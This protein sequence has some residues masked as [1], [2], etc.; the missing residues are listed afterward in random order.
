[1]R[2]TRTLLVGV[3]VAGL[4]LPGAPALG[5]APAPAAQAQLA[6]ATRVFG[7][8]AG[9]VL[10]FIK[11]DKTA[12]F[13]TVMA[14]VRDAL[15]GSDK[16]LRQQQARSWKVFKSPDPASGGAALYVFLSDPAVKGADYTITTILAET[17]PA[18]D[19]A[20]L[21]RQYTECFASGQNWVN[22]ALIAD[23]G[24]PKP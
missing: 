11:P 18:E 10:N 24:A 9:L 4:C 13:E 20:A 5:Q 3:S 2:A 12:Q 21:T 19:A 8:D 22:L 16:P 6:P 17:L 1:M 14:K 15:A 7:S 23:F